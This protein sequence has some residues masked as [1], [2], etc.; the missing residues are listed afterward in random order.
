MP[1]SIMTFSIMTL[2]KMSFRIMTFS[3][4]TFSM[5]ALSIMALSMIS[6]S[7]TI[8][9]MQHS[10]YWQCCYA[11]WRL[12][13]I[14]SLANKPFMLIVLM[15]NVVLLSFVAPRKRLGDGF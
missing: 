12:S 8:N 15:L 2:S 13:F 5:M 4:V 14:P 3:I 1:F 10:A 7:I 11:E 9:K 6:F